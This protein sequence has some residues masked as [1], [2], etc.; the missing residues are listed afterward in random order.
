MKGCSRTPEWL[1]PS[2]IRILTNRKYLRESS[3][4]LKTMTEMLAALL[5]A[6]AGGMVTLLAARQQMRNEV[7][8]RRRERVD[9]LVA[10]LHADFEALG[11][12]GRAG[13][14]PP[15]ERLE[16]A[17]FRSSVLTA[18]ARDLSPHLAMVVDEGS[19]RFDEEAM[20]AMRTSSD[21]K[22]RPC[23]RTCFGIAYL[24]GLW[25]RDPGKF[26]KDRPTLD[27]AFAVVDEHFPEIAPEAPS[28]GSIKSSG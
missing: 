18:R 11:V 12:H 21:S 22:W 25:L 8:A 20:Q 17:T 16:S 10:Q 14:E 13:L 19:G 9:E 15:Q 28:L 24:L 27:L 4:I 23:A 5:G 7:D 6:L 26:E 1:Q 3:G 2:R